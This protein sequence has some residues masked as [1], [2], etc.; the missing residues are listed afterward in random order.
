MD[1]VNATLLVVDMDVYGRASRVREP[2]SPGL[3]SASS[4]A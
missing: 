1:D 4:S 2:V 3:L